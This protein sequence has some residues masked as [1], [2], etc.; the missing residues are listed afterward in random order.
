MESILHNY[1]RM[2]LEHLAET[3]P[4]MLRKMAKEEP[5]ELIGIL[6]AKVR[7]GI[8]W[9]AYCSKQGFREDEVIE[10]VNAI[11]CPPE[12][13]V[14]DHPMSMA[15]SDKIFTQLLKRESKKAI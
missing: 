11:L 7:T 12:D 5:D 14:S 4:T 8:Q 10:L 9:E 15:A 13:E 6:A 1:A 2:Y 3:K